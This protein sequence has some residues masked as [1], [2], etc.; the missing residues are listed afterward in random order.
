MPPRATNK[1]VSRSKPK[2]SKVMSLALSEEDD[3]YEAVREKNIAERNAF[4]S[5][6][7]A[8]CREALH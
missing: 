7:F 6:M 4:V 3:D 2:K 5:L 1:S 8:R